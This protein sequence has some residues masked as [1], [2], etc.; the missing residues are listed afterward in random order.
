VTTTII[1][2]AAIVENNENTLLVYLDVADDAGEI[3]IYHG[4]K[5]TIAPLS[6][7]RPI[8]ALLAAHRIPSAF[9]GPSNTRY[10]LGLAAGS[11]ALEFA[12]AGE[13]PAIELRSQKSAPGN[14]RISAEELAGFLADYAE[15]VETETGRGDTNYTIINYKGRIRFVSEGITLFLLMISMGIV[16]ALFFL[17]PQAI[18]DKR[19]WA[20]IAGACA[21][22]F[23]IMELLGMTAL[24]ITW[25]LILIWAMG[26][27]F[28][29]GIVKYPP[30][31]FSCAILAPLATA[32]L[33]NT[34]TLIE[35]DCIWELLR[36]PLPR[37]TPLTWEP[38]SA[39]KVL[40]LW[41]TIPSF[42]LLIC[43]G[44]LSFRNTPKRA[45]PHVG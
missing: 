29:G 15:S 39:M 3:G 30:L 16:L 14:P 20:D 6:L 40:L 10:R 37:G 11:P 23:V 45:R 44:I 17:K 31:I 32:V 42:V 8:P 24:D 19:R 33:T 4:T 18:H 26:F 13:L 2:T 21:L 5:G 9:P 34:G 38:L 36:S 41:G 25:S 12:R 43:R 28:L 1:D 22:G 7:I 27:T 35:G